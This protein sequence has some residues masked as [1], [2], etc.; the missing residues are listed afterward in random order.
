VWDASW[1][2]L[3]FFSKNPRPAR[4]PVSTKTLEALESAETQPAVLTSS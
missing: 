4:E 3:L 2:L 1:L